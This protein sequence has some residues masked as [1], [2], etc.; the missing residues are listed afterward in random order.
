M[1]DMLLLDK[2]KLGLLLD[3]RTLLHDL[4]PLAVFVIGQEDAVLPVD[5]TIRFYLG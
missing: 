2:V 4:S 3:C 5:R 1:Q